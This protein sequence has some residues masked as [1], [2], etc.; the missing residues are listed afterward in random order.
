MRT[1]SSEFNKKKTEVN[2]G[3]TLELKNNKN[4]YV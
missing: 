1:R 3:R 4:K 2:I